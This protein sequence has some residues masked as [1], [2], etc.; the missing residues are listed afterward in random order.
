MKDKSFQDILEE[1]LVFDDFD[2]EIE[3]KSKA[4]A[5]DFDWTQIHLTRNHFQQE[6]WK[7]HQIYK[8]WKSQFSKLNHE[9]I[10][11][12]IPR[13]EPQPKI[14]YLKE[15]PNSFNE[16]QKKAFNFFLNHGTCFE[17]NFRLSDIKHAFKKLARSLHPDAVT[18]LGEQHVKKHN[19][20]FKELL[21]SYKILLKVQF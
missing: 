17:V 15:A 1:K 13:D 14:E 3:S 6:S 11:K 9:T 16:Q 19:D 4:S 5:S 7:I 2:T 10:N 18:H 12:N 20:I 8:S 21:S